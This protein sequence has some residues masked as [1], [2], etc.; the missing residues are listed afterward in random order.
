MPLPDTIN[1]TYVPG[2]T[3]EIQALDLNDTQKWGCVETW[4]IFRHAS[5][6]INEDFT[7]PSLAAAGV[8]TPNFTD[9]GAAPVWAFFD[10]SAN[11]ASGAV[12]FN[13][14]ATNI[15]SLTNNVHTL[16]LGQGDLWLTARC[17]VPSIGGNNS[18][19]SFGLLT[20]GTNVLTMNYNPT[21]NGNSNWWLWYGATPTKVD[22]GVAVATSS[23][24]KID[25]VRTAGLIQVF[26][27]DVQKISTSPT[28]FSLDGNYPIING[29]ASTSGTTTCVFDYFKLW[30]RTA[31]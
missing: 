24:Q 26:I 31:R 19:V 8:T 16:A 9:G 15:Q 29:N 30:A 11:G 27:D 14:A 23:H 20:V 2:S 17:R 18:N 25:I 10:D 1:T 22:T 12:R 7:C 28:P 6:L 3:P 13:F 4:A 21:V 5:L